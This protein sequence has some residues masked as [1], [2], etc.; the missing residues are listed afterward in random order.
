MMDDYIEIYGSLWIMEPQFKRDRKYSLS[1]LASN[2]Y[3]RKRSVVM[4]TPTGGSVLKFHVL[5][6]SIFSKPI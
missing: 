6:T 4:R 3:G 1:I 2:F 5:L